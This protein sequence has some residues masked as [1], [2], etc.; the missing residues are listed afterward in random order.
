MADRGANRKM[1]EGRSRY[2]G[3]LRR[4]IVKTV[5]KKIEF[6]SHFLDECRRIT[7]VGPFD[8]RARPQV[9]DG[10][11]GQFEAEIIAQLVRLDAYLEES[12]VE[13]GTRG[14]VD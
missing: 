6:G 10:M 8:K 13:A 1:R 12:G 14:A 2:N 9:A 3:L 11:S 5:E 7:F 4:V